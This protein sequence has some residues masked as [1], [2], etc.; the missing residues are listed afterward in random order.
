MPDQ[1][2]A[3]CPQVASRAARMGLAGARRL[4]LY[5][6]TRLA[7]VLSEI[8]ALRPRAVVI[9]SIQT[10]YLDDVSGSAGSVSQART[11]ALCPPPLLKF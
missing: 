7:E 8:V 4:Y 5:A 3:A 10:V 9:D 11:H 6:A 1:A 2:C